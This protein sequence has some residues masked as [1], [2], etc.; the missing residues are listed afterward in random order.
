MQL[1]D[2]NGSGKN[3]QHSYIYKLLMANASLVSGKG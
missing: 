2:L 3:K 1:I